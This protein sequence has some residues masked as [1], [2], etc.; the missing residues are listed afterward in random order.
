MNRTKIRLV[1][2]SKGI[3]PVPSAKMLKVGVAPASIWVVTL[4]AGG[5][6]Q[7]AVS[8]LVWQR[9]RLRRVSK[10]EGMLPFVFSVFAAVETAWI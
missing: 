3:E 5:A 4:G 1:A 9:A 8:G 7:A 10:W 6:R 2:A